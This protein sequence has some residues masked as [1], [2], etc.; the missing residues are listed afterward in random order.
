M[1]IRS[2]PTAGAVLAL[3]FLAACSSGR[4]SGTG[5]VVAGG[6][7]PA[8]LGT[9]ALNNVQAAACNS[10]GTTANTY[11]G[12]TKWKGAGG[13]SFTCFVAP[14]V[15]NPYT[16][17]G[18]SGTSVFG[19]VTTGSFAGTI[20]AA[21]GNLNGAAVHDACYINVSQ[22]VPKGP[23]Q[24]TVTAKAHYIYERTGTVVNGT[25]TYVAE[26]TSGV[27]SLH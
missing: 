22:S 17:S 26:N 12:E 15:H 24:A 7:K 20:T 9:F 23:W 8:T 4:F 18:G 10:I 2:I 13:E 16:Y 5:S 27:C 19:T 1:L 3:A 6:L 14:T 11:R 21:S 25:S